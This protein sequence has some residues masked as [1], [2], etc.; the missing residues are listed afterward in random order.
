MLGKT[1]KLINVKD[2]Q[3]WGGTSTQKSLS[4]VAQD[5]RHLGI[6]RIHWVGGGASMHWGRGSEAIQY[7]KWRLGLL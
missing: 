2:A 5:L 6:Q 7:G 1:N 4:S 3:V